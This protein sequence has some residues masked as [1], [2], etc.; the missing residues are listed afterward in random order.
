MNEK[1]LSQ[2]PSPAKMVIISYIVLVGAGLLLA[3]WV[4]IESPVWRGSGSTDPIQQLRDAGVPEEE[5]KAAK[6]AQFYTYLKQA[7]IHH[8]G[9]ILMVLSVAGIYAFTRG[10]NSLKTQI[11]IW[12]SIV[13]LIHTLG[14]LIYSRLLLIFFGT[15]YGGLLAYMMVVIVI[16]CYKPIRE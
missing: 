8:L 15:A 5:I 2:L 16:D 10:K 6:A 4:V 14:F 3:L 7:H 13:T 12:T 1:G 9:H 11:I